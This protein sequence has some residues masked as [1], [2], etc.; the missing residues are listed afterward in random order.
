MRTK[1]EEK[2][3]AIVDA[4]AAIFGEM[5]FER[6]SMSEICA[7]V[8][9]SKATLYNYFAS[10]EDLFLEVIFQASEADFQN[11]LQALQHREGDVQ[12]TL[13]RFGSQYL[14]LLYTPDV[15]A[16]RRL[17][18]AQ[19]GRSNIGRMC[20]EQGPRRG[21]AAIAAYLAH[22]MARGALR[23]ASPELAMRH[24]QALLEAELFEIFLFQH[25]PMPEAPEIAACTQ[26]AIAAFMQLYGPQPS[27]KTGA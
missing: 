13:E 1:S 12:A 11:T 6:A 25:V 8:G 10:K 5:G 20:W 19:G 3:Q 7:R 9:G 27:A 21:N 17:L 22:C 2:R 14:G 4:A 24:L 23:S 18:V 15:L 26:R 16:V